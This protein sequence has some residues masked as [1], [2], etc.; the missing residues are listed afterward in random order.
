M[1]M[2]RWRREFPLSRLLRQ[3]AVCVC[4]WLRLPLTR[5]RANA[6]MDLFDDL[7]E[8][9]RATNASFAD[10]SDFIVDIREYDVPYHVRV[11][12]DLGRSWQTRGRRNVSDECKLTA[13][14]QI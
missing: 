2:L 10:A 13:A 7:R 4:V 6:N 5:P 14:Q 11:M 9:E 3:R 12:I 8:D 1:R